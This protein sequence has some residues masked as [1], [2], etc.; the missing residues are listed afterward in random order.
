[1][2]DSQHSTVAFSSGVELLTKKTDGED[3]VVSTNN[4]LP[5]AMLLI[6]LVEL[7]GIEPT[8]S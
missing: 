6:K 1:M 2:L 5:P 8:T 4:P 7:I 3:L